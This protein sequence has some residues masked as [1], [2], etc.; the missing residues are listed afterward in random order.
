MDNIDGQIFFS[1]TWQNDKL[2]RNNHSRVYE[3]AKKIRNCGWSIWIDEEKMIGNIDAAM[4][5]GIDNAEVVIICLTEAYFKKINE[6]ANNPRKRDN[7]LKEWT[8]TNTRNKLI[9]PVVME[10]FLLNIN[11]WPA[12]IISLQLGSTLFINGALDNLN[13]CVIQIN[14]LLLRYG[15]LPKNK[16]DENI[17]FRTSGDLSLRNSN[18]SSEESYN[19]FSEKSINNSSNNNYNLRDNFKKKKI[20]IRIKILNILIKQKKV[21]PIYNDNIN[22]TI[23]LYNTNIPPILSSNNLLTKTKK[24][25]ITTKK[26]K[27]ISI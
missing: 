7:C 6:S 14:D 20:K 25:W 4:A 12:G 2:N 9:I 3:L 18:I 19:V 11:N 26:I 16:N 1:H 10:P 23:P 21:Y 17:S 15:L 8:Y 24:L 5:N 27:R 22:K 13:N